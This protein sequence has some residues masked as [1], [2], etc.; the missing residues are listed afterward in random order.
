M[1]SIKLHNLKV[2]CIIV[3]ILETILAIYVGFAMDTI[4]IG[5]I[6]LAVSALP[7]AILWGVIDCLQTLAENLDQPEQK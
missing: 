4:W 3:A 1:T 5:L 6:V 7:L 2:I